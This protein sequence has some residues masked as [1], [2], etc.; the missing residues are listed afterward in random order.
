M[1]RHNFVASVV[2]IVLWAPA[3]IRYF[4]YKEVNSKTVSSNLLRMLYQIISPCHARSFSLM[5]V[6]MVVIRDCQLGGVRGVENK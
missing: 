5:L 3:V 6:N 1:C 2:A 4:R